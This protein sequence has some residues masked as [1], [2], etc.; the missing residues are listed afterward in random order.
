M[1]VDI[2]TVIKEIFLFLQV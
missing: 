2:N 1:C